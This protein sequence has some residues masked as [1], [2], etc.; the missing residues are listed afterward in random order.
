[1]PMRGVAREIPDDTG[2]DADPQFPFAD[3]E[4]YSVPTP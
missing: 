2:R 3:V 4:G 1:M